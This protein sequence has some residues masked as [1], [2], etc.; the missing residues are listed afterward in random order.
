MGICSNTGDERPGSLAFQ[1]FCFGQFGL[2]IVE[3][4]KALGFEFE[5]AGDMQAIERS[6]TEFLTVAAGE[7]GTEFKGMVRHRGAEP[8]A[9]LEVVLKRD[10]DALRI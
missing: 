9:V 5:R 4:P 8:Q 3:S 10:L 1:S 7:V 2:P 6:D